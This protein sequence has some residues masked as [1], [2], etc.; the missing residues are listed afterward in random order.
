MFYPENLPPVPVSVRDY[1]VL[2]PDFRGGVR[3]L[4]AHSE[5][6]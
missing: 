6:S 4:S 2:Q 5:R 1:S 3:L